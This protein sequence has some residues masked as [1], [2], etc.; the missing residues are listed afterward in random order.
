MST[1]CSN[2]L[3][4]CKLGSRRVKDHALF[5]ST[6][7]TGITNDLL[8]TPARHPIYASGIS[9]LHAYNAITR[10]WARLQHYCAIMISSGLLLLTLVVKNHLF[11]STSLQSKTAAIVNQTELAPYIT[12]LESSTWHHAD[13]KLLMWIESDLGSW[14]AHGNARSSDRSFAIDRLLL[15]I[16]ARFRKILRR[17]MG[18]SCARRPYI[19]K[20]ILRTLSEG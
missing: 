17:L 2:T 18:S 1:I 6:R 8:V 11:E 16:C 4:M 10:G 5:K 9:Q 20:D 13:A 3:P 15:L 7:P 19:L 12:N 14:F